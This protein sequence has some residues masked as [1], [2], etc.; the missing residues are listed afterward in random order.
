VQVA[1]IV[2]IPF[3]LPGTFVQLAA[4]IVLAAA[5]GGQLL[6]WGWVAVFVV[7]T[8]FGELV[9]FL[10]GQWGARRFGGSPRAAW[11]ALIGGVAGA[12]VGG[13][14]IP[15]IGSIVMSFVGTFLGALIGELSATARRPELRVGFGA[16]VGRVVGV[17][18]KLGIGMAML[19]T[20]V[21]VVAAR[22]AE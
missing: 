10:S 15:V 8:L 18:V 4:A 1:G 20:S 21:V 16:V 5:T 14:P 12:V 9:E 2:L 7:L 3:G 19:V 17:A 6:G 13:I 11:G 22:L